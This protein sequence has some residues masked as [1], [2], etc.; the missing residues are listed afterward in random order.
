MAQLILWGEV[1]IGDLASGRI[2]RCLTRGKIEQY[3]VSDSILVM[4]P[5]A[6]WPNL[7]WLALLHL[8][9]P[10]VILTVYEQTSEHRYPEFV[11][12]VNEE[13]IEQ[14]MNSCIHRHAIT[15]DPRE[16][17]PIAE[18]I[19]KGD[20][21]PPAP[22]RT[23]P[24]AVFFDNDGTLTD[25][26]GYSVRA[27][28]NAMRIVYKRHGIRRRVPAVRIILPRMG[29]KIGGLYESLLPEELRSLG[30]EIA[31]EARGE[32]DRLIPEGR[33]FPTVETTLNQ[34]RNGGRKL[35]LVSTST[36]AYFY[37]VVDEF[38]LARRF[39][40]MI[41][42]GERPGAGKAEL[43]RELMQRWNVT[44]AWMVGDRRIDIEAGKEAGCVTVGCRYG[45]GIDNELDGADHVIDSPGELLVLIAGDEPINNR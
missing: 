11:Q 38:G 29:L 3:L 12:V 35:G 45:Y 22:P 26:A 9:L 10:R 27:I 34:L 24:Q 2:V 37:R 17:I 19:L 39:D 4:D 28:Q 14:F 8:A 13:N 1:P 25:S 6:F 7:Q 23:K 33:L 31:M 20:L 32:F 15:Y 5:S 18:R 42:Q 16:F 40:G 43:I 30:A 41:C 44:T 21:F 36:P